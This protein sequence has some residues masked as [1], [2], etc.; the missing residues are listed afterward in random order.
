MKSAVAGVEGTVLAQVGVAS[1]P[2]GQ[3]VVVVGHEI[4]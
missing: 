3:H 4:S 2:R 1:V